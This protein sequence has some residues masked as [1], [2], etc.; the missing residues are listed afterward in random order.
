MS[1]LRQNSQYPHETNKIQ[2]SQII[3]QSRNVGDKVFFACPKGY[4]LHGTHH[5]LHC[6]ESGEWSGSVPYCQG[7]S[8]L[9]N[10]SKQLNWVL[11]YRGEM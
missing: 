4:G 11:V 1:D 10:S 6:L 5:E 7:T 8:V 3:Q 9:T 2:P